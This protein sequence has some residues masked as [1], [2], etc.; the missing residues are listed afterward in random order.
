MRACADNIFNV[1][2]LSGPHVKAHQRT[3]NV[4]LRL[5][6][7][8]FVNRS[9]TNVLPADYKSAT[10]PDGISRNAKYHSSTVYVVDILPL[11]SA[12]WQRFTLRRYISFRWQ[13]RERFDETPYNYHPY[14]YALS[15]P[16]LYVDPAGEAAALPEEARKAELRDKCRKLFPIRL[17]DMDTLRDWECFDADTGK[18]LALEVREYLVP[19]F[20]Q[21]K[22]H[23]SFERAFARFLK[24]LQ[25]TE[26]PPAPAP[27]QAPTTISQA[28]SAKPQ[29]PS[30]IIARKK[31]RLAVLEEQQAI[32]G[33]ST[34]PELITEIEDLRREIEE[35]EA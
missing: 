18:D 24:D 10:L 23:D 32:K 9:S 22:D 34:P 27:V 15:N 3:A 8:R 20:T 6:T 31:R 5:L 14:A 2:V 7:I 33:I 35:L 13:T 25:A 21:C 16:I 4:L 1:A 19:D 26:A 11:S 30:T 28:R 29:N 12:A 17:V